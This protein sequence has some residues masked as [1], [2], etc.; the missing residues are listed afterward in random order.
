MIFVVGAGL[1]KPL[2]AE[3][4]LFTVFVAFQLNVITDVLVR[5]FRRDLCVGGAY[6][7]K[8][9][10]FIKEQ[11]RLRIRSYVYNLC[12]WNHYLSADVAVYRDIN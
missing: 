7:G 10:S 9:S 8:R 11:I 2:G 6:G 3:E 4:A 5:T 12:L 1:P